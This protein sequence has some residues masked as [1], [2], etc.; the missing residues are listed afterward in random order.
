M[1]TELQDRTMLSEP[2][3]EYKSV[4]LLSVLAFALGLASVLALLSPIG[5]VVPLAGSII[6]LDATI[7]VHR[8]A[9][10][11]TGKT[12]GMIGMCLSL[13]LGAWGP[14]KYFADRQFLSKASAEYTEQW[15]TYVVTGE[16]EIAHQATLEFRF[17]QPLGTDL[18][19]HYRTSEIDRAD[20]NEY[21]SSSAIKHVVSRPEGTVIQRQRIRT[22]SREKQIDNIVNIFIIDPPNDE[23]ITLAVEAIRE[24]HKNNFYWR[25]SGSGDPVELFG[26]E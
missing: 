22:I 26:E 21:F 9:D 17:R 11:F 8:N 13:W 12:L 4:S 10:R 3:F 2:E 6:S 7:R 16:I 15:L 18:K 19:E 24:R 1:T 14:T 25:I 5:W 20:M 23:P